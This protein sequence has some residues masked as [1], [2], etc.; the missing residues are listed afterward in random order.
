MAPRLVM[1]GASGL[2]HRCR[3][4]RPLT[5]TLSP[6]DGARENGQPREQASRD[7]SPR[8]FLHPMEKGRE[9]RTQIGG[10]DE[11]R[12]V[13]VHLSLVIRHSA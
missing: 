7:L 13:M 5:P 2:H 4:S 6:S 8:P 10:V 1:V 3:K 9:S 12:P 11:M